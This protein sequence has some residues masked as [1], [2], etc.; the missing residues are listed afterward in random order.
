MRVRHI[1]YYHLMKRDLILEL[2]PYHQFRRS[3]M[4]MILIERAPLLSSMLRFRRFT[5][6]SLQGSREEL[7]PQVISKPYDPCCV[8]YEASHAENAIPSAAKVKQEVIPGESSKADKLMTNGL[9]SPGASM[10][11]HPKIETHRLRNERHHRPESKDQRTK[12]KSLQRYLTVPS[13]Q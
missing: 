8:E 9:A 1:L 6:E 4:P 2:M 10:P 12:R 13:Y 7:V 11:G 3:A 5:D